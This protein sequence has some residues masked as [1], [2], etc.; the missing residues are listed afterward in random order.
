MRVGAPLVTD[1]THFQRYFG[2]HLFAHP[3]LLSWAGSPLLLTI[4]LTVRAPA[5]IFSVETGSPCPTE[6]PQ[7]P[8]P[9]LD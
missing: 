1:C 9:S 8:L 3:N 5:V 7:S 2:E 4:N 6:S